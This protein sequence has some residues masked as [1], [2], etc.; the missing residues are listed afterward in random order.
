M[1]LTQD[2]KPIKHHLYRSQFNKF[3]SIPI[4]SVSSKEFRSF[5]KI[6][7][8]VH[9]LLSRLYETTVLTFPLRRNINTHK[10]FLCN[11]LRFSLLSQTHLPT[12]PDAHP[13]FQG[14]RPY[15]RHGFRL[16]Q[17][18]EAVAEV[19][20]AVRFINDRD[21][22][23]VHDE[24]RYRKLVRTADAP[25]VVPPI[26]ACPDSGHGDRVQKLSFHV[27]HDGIGVPDLW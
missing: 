1:R 3:S 5:S 4:C 18:A 16:G 12:R 24:R 7:K 13:L 15:D 25:C 17:A 27:F 6:K 10:S 26:L 23:D 14:S 19:N 2:L 8:R 21:G 22:H 20:H 11:P 9:S